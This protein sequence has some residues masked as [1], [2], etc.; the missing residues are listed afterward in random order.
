MTRQPD[1]RKGVNLAKKVVE[2]SISL[3]YHLQIK[4]NEIDR[5]TT[6]FPKTFIVRYDSPKDR[7]FVNFGIYK[8]IYFHLKSHGQDKI[9]AIPFNKMFRVILMRDGVYHGPHIVLQRI[10][11]IMILSSLF[12][13]NNV[14]NVDN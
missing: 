8:I 5:Y 12:N 7:S 10:S 2:I 14:D 4:C 13:R 11:H 6:I 3:I 9:D 1:R